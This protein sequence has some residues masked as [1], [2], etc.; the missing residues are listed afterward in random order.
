M[1][2]PDDEAP[3]CE[4]EGDVELQEWLESLDDVL[5]TGG[6]RRA[7]ELLRALGLRAAERGISPPPS[8]TTPYVNTIPPAAEPRYPGDRA[9]ER[10]IKSLIRWNAM[11]MVVRANREEHGIGG[12]ISTYASAATSSTSRGTRRPASTRT[13]SSR[14]GSPSGSWSPSAASSA[15]AAASRLTPTPG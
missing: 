9:L 12:H 4:P 2:I 14:A 3:L 6:P 13:P 1:A 11:A 7:G 15:P 8:I 5:A 10:R